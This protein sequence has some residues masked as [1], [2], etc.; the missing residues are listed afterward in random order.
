MLLTG[1]S[2]V[3]QVQIKVSE[4][5]Y[6][7][8]RSIVESSTKPSYH[9][10]KPIGNKFVKYKGETRFWQVK[11][12]PMIIRR[13]GAE[14]PA[15]KIVVEDGFGQ[16][17]AEL[18]VSEYKLNNNSYYVLETDDHE[19]KASSLYDFE[20]YFIVPAEPVPYA[21]PIPVSSFVNKLMFYKSLLRPHSSDIVFG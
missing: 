13:G 12:L 21:K 8:I 20:H 18:I 10:N 1:E 9:F 15:I 3:S 5:T 11:I 17:V 6:N 16:R 19:I 2:N 14:L 7:I 4:R